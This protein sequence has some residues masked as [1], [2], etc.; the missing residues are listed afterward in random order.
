MEINGTK[1]YIASS[2][3][4]RHGQSSLQGPDMTG[5]R[6]GHCSATLEDGSIIMTGGLTPNAD[7]SSLTEV[8]NAT[9]LQWER[10]SDMKHRRMYHACTSVWLNQHPKLGKGFL[11]ADLWT[12]GNVLS[13]MVAGG[14]L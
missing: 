3:L 11:D 6:A 4:I 14:E 9:T 10:R 2:Q 12:S 8:Y 13:I 1:S 5:P 7:G